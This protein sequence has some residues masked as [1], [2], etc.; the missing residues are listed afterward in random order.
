MNDRY[1]RQLALSVIGAEGQRKLASSCVAVLGCGALGSRQAELVARAGVGRLIIVDRDV[2]ELH[3]LPRQTLLDEPDVHERR[4]K[5]Q[6]AAGHL[7]AVNSEIAIDA[8]TADITRDNIESLLRDADLVLDATDNFETRYL[9]N[10]LCVKSNK[11]WVYGGVLGTAGAALA[12]RPGVGPCL[13]CVFPEAPR[14][15][16]L[17]TC[18]TRGVLNTAVA[19]VAALQVTEALKLILDDRAAAYPLYGLDI[20]KGSL[21]T[22]NIRRSDGCVCCGQRRFDFLDGHT[23]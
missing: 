20:W 10:D 2:V 15:H 11:P 13:R 14:T 6:A 8:V 21:R 1:Q 19:W 4:S 22:V 5:A 9:L 23:G 16:A 3:N 12:V 7:R 18:E 17:P